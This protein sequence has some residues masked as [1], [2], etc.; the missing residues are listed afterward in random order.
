MTFSVIVH[1]L[2]RPSLFFSHKYRVLYNGYHHKQSYLRRLN[3]AAT[4]KVHLWHVATGATGTL[5]YDG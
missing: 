1:N 3:G 5:I 2:I 4:N